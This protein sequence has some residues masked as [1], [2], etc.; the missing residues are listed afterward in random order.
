MSGILQAME[1]ASDQGANVINMSLGA[2]QSDGTDPLSREV[3]AISNQKG[4]LFAIAAGNSGPGAK[5]ST[6]AAADKSLAVGA[7]DKAGIMAIFSSRGP[8]YKTW[9]SSRC[10]GSGRRYHCRT[11]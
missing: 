10:R 7:I 5:V 3:N 6:P 2:G 4:V 9:R 1:W 11:S 8:R